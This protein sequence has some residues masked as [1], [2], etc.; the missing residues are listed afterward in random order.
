M[1]FISGCICLW[2]RI[3]SYYIEARH[4]RF[5]SIGIAKSAII[6]W[7]LLYKKHGAKCL[8]FG[9]TNYTKKFKIEVLNYMEKTVSSVLKTALRLQFISGNWNRKLEP[10]DIKG[11]FPKKRVKNSM[12]EKKR[13]KQLEPNLL[14]AV[15]EENNKLRMENDYLKKLNALVQKERELKINKKRK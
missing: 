14:E 12:T 3:Q 11:L 15:I 2:T 7:V 10:N 9:C 1:G 8:L 5:T 13:E 4:Q 6:H